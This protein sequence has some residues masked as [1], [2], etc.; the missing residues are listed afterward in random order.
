MKKIIYKIKASKVLSNIGWILFG[1]IIYMA[2]NFIVGLLSARYLGPSN[3]GLIGYA[4]A[5]TTFFYSICTLG[6]NSVIIKE[7]I[8]NP[9][10]EGKI[11][12]TSLSLKL[13]SSLISLVV[14]TGFCYIV[15][16]NEPLTKIVVFLYSISIVFQIFETFNFWFQSR[17]ESKYPEII[18]TIGYIIMA[19]YKIILLI[20][21]QSVKWFAL[22]NSV[23]YF[24]IAV[25]LYIVYKKKGGQ[26]LS[27]S[28]EYGKKILKSSYHFI[29]TGLMI[30]IYNSTDKFMLKQMIDETSVGYYTTAT[31]ISNLTTLLLSAIIT[32]LTPEILK[33]HKSNKKEYEKKNIQ[34]YSLIF[35]ISVTISIVVCI[36]APLLINILFGTEYEGTINTLKILTW[37][38]VFSY[39]GCARDPWIVAENKQKYLKYIYISCATLNIILNFIL[40]PNLGASGAAF[41]SLITQFAT[42]FVIPLFIRELRPNVKLM[43]DGILLKE[44]DLKKLFKKEDKIY[45]RK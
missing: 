30:S 25:L 6:I 37:Y 40:I 4:A 33:V 16:N 3:Y 44:F 31:T 19:V 17:L 34:L 43:V 23:D 7:F 35:Y 5:Y 27:F 29:F 32:S 11:I 42:I 41:A 20:T 14:I 12:G 36:L 9:Q 26:K 45:E 2:L 15:D 28:W 38:I 13:I 22:S 24:V 21:N 8:D 10:S 18:S 1:R 39:L